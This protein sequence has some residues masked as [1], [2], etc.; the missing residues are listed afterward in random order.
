MATATYQSP[1]G[2]QTVEVEG[3]VN[4]DDWFGRTMVVMM[5]GKWYVVEAD[6]LQDAIDCIVDSEEY[7]KILTISEE[8]AEEW[9]ADGR[10]VYRAGNFGEPVDLEGVWF[11]RHPKCTVNSPTAV[12]AEGC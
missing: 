12:E 7:G 10:E 3:F 6:H 4:P 5:G 11:P 2:P 1:Q 9:E 8:T